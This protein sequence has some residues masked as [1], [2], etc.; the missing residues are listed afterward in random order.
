MT[1]VHTILCIDDDR[2]VHAVLKAAL[3]RSGHF[4]MLSATERE[5]GIELARSA[6]PDMILLDWIMPGMGGM[7]ALR[8]LKGDSRTTW[9]PVFMLTAKAKMPD[10]ECALENGATGY[11]TK[12]VDLEAVQSRLELY[13]EGDDPATKQGAGS[14]ASAIKR[15]LSA[16]AA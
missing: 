15:F 7:E 8:E 12:P 11:F 10:V 3:E 16:F 1:Q 6:N 9:I 2:T 14:S 5:Q 4:R 13:F